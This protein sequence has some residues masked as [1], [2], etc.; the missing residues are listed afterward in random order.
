MGVLGQE[1]GNT[2]VTAPVGAGLVA[3]ADKL[4]DVR[5]ILFDIDAGMLRVQDRDGR[6]VQY[7]Y[8]DIATVTYTIANNTAE[9]VAST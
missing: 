9:V 1:K 3:T 2:T 7:A 8:D 6:W 5:A 4:T